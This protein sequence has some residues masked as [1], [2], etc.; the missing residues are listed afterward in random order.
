MIEVIIKMNDLMNFLFQV[1]FILLKSDIFINTKYWSFSGIQLSQ[2]FKVDSIRAWYLIQWNKVRWS[3]VDLI[4]ISWR[5]A[6]PSLVILFL[7]LSAHD[8]TTWPGTVV[9]LFGSSCV[10]IELQNGFSQ[11]V[12]SKV[13]ESCENTQIHFMLFI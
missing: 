5:V 7:S 12:S 2:N 1:T 11:N 6:L 13:S 3:F 9:G 10:S 8:W 4:H